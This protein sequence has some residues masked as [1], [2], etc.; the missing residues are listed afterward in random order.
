MASSSKASCLPRS[1]CALYSRSVRFDP[2]RP[3]APLKP[4]PA[5]PPFRQER[6]ESLLNTIKQDLNQLVQK[7]SQPPESGR[8]HT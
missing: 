4:R 3:N 5:Q 7:Q 6:L 2:R 8:P 1:L